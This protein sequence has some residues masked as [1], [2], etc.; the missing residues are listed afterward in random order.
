[1]QV[2]ECT[3]EGEVRGSKSMSKTQ[4]GK[5]STPEMNY[6]ERTEKSFLKGASVRVRL[7]RLLVGL[8][9]R[10][11]GSIPTARLPPAAAP[12]WQLLLHPRSLVIL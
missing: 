11:Q 6:K 9:V 1:M 4:S 7:Q 8:A 5:E 2:P 12:V 10:T 3:A